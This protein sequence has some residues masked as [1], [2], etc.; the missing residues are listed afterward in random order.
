MRGTRSVVL[1][2][3]AVAGVIWA[4]CQSSSGPSNPRLTGTFS[5]SSPCCGGGTMTL[6]MSLT[7]TGTTVSG[8]GTWTTPNTTQAMTIAGTMNFPN[9]S[10]TLTTPG[11]NP[12]VI[13]GTL[14][15]AGNQISGAING[16]GF[17]NAAITFSK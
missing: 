10:L 6:T 15:Q 2:A 16:S 1:I 14:N 5:G 3:A 9:L 7:Q 8:S 17:N 11:F 12:M 13:T 4:G